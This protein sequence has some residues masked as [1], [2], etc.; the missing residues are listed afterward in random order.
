M[1]IL[2]ETVDFINNGRKYRF[3]MF[4]YMTLHFFSLLL[5]EKAQART[6][7]VLCT[8]IDTT[9]NIG[10]VGKWILEGET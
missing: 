8:Q 2:L 4:A 3:V 1:V 7:L 10:D 9:K 5:N 6:W